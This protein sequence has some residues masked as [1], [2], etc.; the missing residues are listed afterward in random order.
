MFAARSHLAPRIQ[1]LS[2]ISAVANFHKTTTDMRPCV[3]PEEIIQITDSPSPTGYGQSKFVAEHIFDMSSRK[4][5][6]HSTI[7]RIG[8]IAGSAQTMSG[9]NC[10]EWLP[11]LV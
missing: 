8:Q 6:V 9:W 3:V 1:Y 4:L 7:V 11:S 10:N 5:N 2:S